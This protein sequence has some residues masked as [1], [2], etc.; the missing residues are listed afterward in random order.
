M[1]IKKD[2]LY[3]EYV[4]DRNL[5]PGTIRSYT[6]KLQIYSKVTGLTLTQLIE[7]AE[8]AEDG[9]KKIFRLGI[10]TDKKVVQNKT[11]FALLRL[12]NA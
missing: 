11:P 4:L 6:R 5:K 9:M 10:Y 2:H 12:L 8:E 1:D 7:E 3:K